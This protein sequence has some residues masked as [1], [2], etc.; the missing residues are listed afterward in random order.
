[1][2]RA[3]PSATR[4]L[5][6]ERPTG[7]P[8]KD[9]PFSG[10]RGQGPRA[11]SHLSG[12][13]PPG[14]LK[15]AAAP[16]GGLSLFL[17]ASVGIRSRGSRHARRSLKTA[18]FAAV[19]S[20]KSQI[21]LADAQLR[22]HAESAMTVDRTVECDRPRAERDLER[23]ALPRRDQRRVLGADDEVVRDLAGVLDDERVLA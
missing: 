18:A 4:P 2:S 16:L 17:G 12:V 15:P 9:P 22:D 21:A 11:R 20:L 13:S 1:L 19:I 14:T 5:L 8:T 7:Y 23:R 10:G 6:R 3:P